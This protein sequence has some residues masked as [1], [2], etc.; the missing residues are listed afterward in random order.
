MFASPLFVSGFVAF[1]V[2]GLQLE[3]R[4][5]K[6]QYMRRPVF[7]IESRSRVQQLSHWRGN[8]I[9]RLLKVTL[10]GC[11]VI[12]ASVPAEAGILDRILNRSGGRRAGC[13]QPQASCAP[14]PCAS[15]PCASTP[16]VTT[17]NVS[18][19][20]PNCL[21]QYRENLALCD[22][23]FGTDLRKCAECR[24]RAAQAYCECIKDTGTT[25]CK[26]GGRAMMHSTVGISCE[27]P[28][29]YSYESCD[30][31]YDT[32][33]SGGVNPNCAS[34]WFECIRRIPMVPYQ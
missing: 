7:A 34:C 25:T 15:T 12:A 19:Q 18:C 21:G 14:G 33:N 9:S 6:F 10:F 22:R 28:T 11:I 26:C 30:H 16:C 32:C 24:R 1:L 2:S 8:M 27:Q 29:D 17:P 20:T 3:F 5:T 4:P 23:V 31:F 13:C